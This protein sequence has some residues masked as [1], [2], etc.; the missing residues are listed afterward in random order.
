[1]YLHED[2]KVLKSKHT[3]LPKNAKLQLT[4]TLTLGFFKANP[5]YHPVK[6]E[7]FAF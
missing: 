5:L 1:M 4:F 6:K 7:H 2:Y 3:F